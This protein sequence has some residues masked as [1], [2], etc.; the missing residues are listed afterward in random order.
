MWTLAKEMR[1]PRYASMSNRPVFF[2]YTRVR[3]REKAKFHFAFVLPFF[4]LFAFV[5]VLDDIGQL[6]KLFSPRANIH[7]AKEGERSAAAWIASVTGSILDLLWELAMKT[8]PLDLV[9]VDVKDKDESVL[10][11]VLTR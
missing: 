10:V 3:V 5:D 9:D 8:G 1:C 2:L 7:M 11:K 4:I 6:V